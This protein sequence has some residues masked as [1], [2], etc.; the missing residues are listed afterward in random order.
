MSLCD[1]I[2]W[3][4]AVFVWNSEEINIFQ[5]VPFGLIYTNSQK[6][7]SRQGIPTKFRARHSKIATKLDMYSSVSFN[8]DLYW[9][10]RYEWV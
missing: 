8:S 7:N 9:K 4:T 5:I 1:G 6:Y 10:P 3:E 2:W